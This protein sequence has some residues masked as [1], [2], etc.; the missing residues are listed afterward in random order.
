LELV[1]E[2]ALFESDDPVTRTRLY[3]RI[4]YGRRYLEQA[5]LLVSDGAHLPTLTRRLIASIDF[6]AMDAEQRARSRN[7]ARQLARVVPSVR[8]ALGADLFEALVEDFTNSDAFWMERGRSLGENFCFYAWDASGFDLTQ[9]QKD[10]L[11]GCG[12][13]VG[14][15]AAPEVA[16]PWTASGVIT[17]RGARAGE[18]TSTFLSDYVLVDQ[19]GSFAESRNMDA[20]STRVRGRIVINRAP[21]GR[22]F[23]YSV[24]I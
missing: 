20:V 16:C 7:L 5:R 19:S 2:H 24:A 23:A 1:V 10:T 11:M 8:Q 22:V 4:L 15:S 6:A 9:F 3:L 13:G 14:V 21:D 12:V 17:L 18:V